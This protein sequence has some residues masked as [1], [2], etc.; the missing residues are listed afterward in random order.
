MGT[1][2]IALACLLLTVH[3]GPADE[4]Y[5]NYRDFRIPIVLVDKKQTDIH[6]LI[7]FFSKDEG[8]SWQT[9]RE[10]PP[11]EKAF[12]FN[13]TQDGKYWFIVGQED[14]QGNKI[15]RTR[16]GCGPTSASSWTPCR[17]R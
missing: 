6:K 5:L 3:Q 13:A 16:F 14:H 10:A 7:L 1:G 11:T 12:I 2:P 15:P 8:G 17:R 4:W 9:W